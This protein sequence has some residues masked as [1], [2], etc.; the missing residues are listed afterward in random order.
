MEYINTA[1]SHLGLRHEEKPLDS[2]SLALGPIPF[3]E[4]S[5]KQHQGQDIQQPQFISGF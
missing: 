3:L 1:L 2:L 4:L 5:G